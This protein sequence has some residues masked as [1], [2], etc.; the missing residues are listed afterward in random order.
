MPAQRSWSIASPVR[1]TS[2]RQGAASFLCRFLGAS[3][4]RHQTYDRKVPAPNATTLWHATRNQSDRGGV[5]FDETQ[6]KSTTTGRRV[7]VLRDAHSSHVKEIAHDR[8]KAST[9]NAA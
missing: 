7:V 6:L 5:A 2:R 1:T 8:R 9:S 3:P 4:L